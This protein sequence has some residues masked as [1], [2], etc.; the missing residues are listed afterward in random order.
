MRPRNNPPQYNN[1]EGYEDQQ[2][3]QEVATESEYIANPAYG[4]LSSEFLKIQVTYDDVLE[5]I[6]HTLRNER[7]N[8]NG[9]WVEVEPPMFTESGIHSIMKKMKIWMTRDFILGNYDEE[10]ARKLVISFADNLTD[11]LLSKSQVYFTSDNTLDLAELSNII[12]EL[13][14][15]VFANLSRGINGW[16]GNLN[17]NIQQVNETHTYAQ[18]QKQGGM[19]SR[20][21]KKM[22]F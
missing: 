5:Q 20:F 15:H 3:P 11:E 12:H 21:G 6:E 2:A 18:P 4:Q 16:T 14:S 19:F 9:D 10:T 13:S 1:N 8:S 17:R 7:E 22:R